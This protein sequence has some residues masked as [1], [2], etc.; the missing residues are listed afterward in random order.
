M[1]SWPINFELVVRTEI[2]V[3]ELTAAIR[4]TART[5][6]EVPVTPETQERLHRM[7]IVRAVSGT[8][9]IEGVTLTEQEV[10]AV[11]S[12]EG[13]PLPPSRRREEQ[14]VRNAH[15]LFLRV[16]SILRTDPQAVL[17]EHLIQEFHD[18]LTHGIDY[19]NNVPGRYRTHTVTAGDYIAPPA[20][21]VP[22]LMTRFIHWVNR[23]AGAQINPIVRAVVAHFLLVSIHPFGDG[24]GRLSRGIESF[25]LYRA[26]INVRGFY[27]LAN[28]YYQDRQAYI[29]ALTAV[30]FVSDPDVTSFVRFALKGLEEELEWVHGEV[31]DETRLIAFHDYA[32]EVIARDGGLGRSTGR[33]QLELVLG[34]VRAQVPVVDIRSGAHPLARFYRR[35][36]LRTLARDLIALERLGLAVVENGAVRAN[37]AVI[38][39]YTAGLR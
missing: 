3:I 26:G 28:Y 37:L 18:I 39:E 38:D 12:G 29:D 23:G 15:E 10:D 13:P 25:L 24:N 4:A 32:R 20:D 31:I 17:S 36:G 6:R 35:V 5:I 30:R 11:L 21:E 9:G 14:E 16:E 7:N 1:P 27:S 33:R 34:L 8:T 22:A 19:S 2:D